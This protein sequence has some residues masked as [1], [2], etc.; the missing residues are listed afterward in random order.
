MPPTPMPDRRGS[1][2]PDTGH[3]RRDTDEVEDL[4]QW[5]EDHD[6]WSR[7]WTSRME[8]RLDTVEGRA[9]LL[10]GRAG[11]DGGLIGMLGEVRG[12]VKQ[13]SERIE[14][15]AKALDEIRRDVADVKAK[16]GAVDGQ[17]PV[18]RWQR[19]VELVVPIVVASLPVIGTIVAAYLAFKGQIASLGGK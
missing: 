7:E 2:K 3:R 12:E 10:D 8:T 11:N 19:S 16:T 14:R 1:A 18:S 17:K 5:A 9:D 15:H 6:D 13:V 4:R